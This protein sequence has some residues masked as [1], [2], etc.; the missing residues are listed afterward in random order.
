M[1]H[2]NYHLVWRFITWE[3]PVPPFLDLDLSRFL[4]LDLDL[5]LSL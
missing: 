4:F 2:P 3:I 1:V 5:A